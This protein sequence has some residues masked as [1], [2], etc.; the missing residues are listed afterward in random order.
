M[1]TVKLAGQSLRGAVG[2]VEESPGS[3]EQDAG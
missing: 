1:R 3:A 2:Y